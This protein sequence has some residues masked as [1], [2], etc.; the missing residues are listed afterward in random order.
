MGYHNT[1][2]RKREVKSQPNVK[3][4]KKFGGLKFS[5]YLCAMIYEYEEYIE[6]LN[7][8]NNWD[9][10]PEVWLEQDFVN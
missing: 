3:K 7:L 2:N 6:M 1:S 9:E 10:N 8:L 5:T 4:V